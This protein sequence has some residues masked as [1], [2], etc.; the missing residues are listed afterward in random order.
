MAVKEYEV[1]RIEVTNP[2]SGYASEKPISARVSPPPI[3][4]RTNIND[5]MLLKTRGMD[6]KVLAGVVAEAAKGN[7][8]TG[9]AAGCVGRGC[10]DEPVVAEGYTKS[11]FSAGKSFREEGDSI[12]VFEKATEEV[13][14]RGLKAVGVDAP[15]GFSSNTNQTTI[16]ATGSGAD[17]APRLPTLG[18]GLSSTAKLL[19]LFPEGVGVVFDTKKKQYVLTLSQDALDTGLVIGGGQGSS[20]KPLDPDFGPRG[21][22]PVER[23][24]ELTPSTYLRFM[25]AGALCCSTVHLA[26]TPL[27]VVKT[28]L[29][30][31]PKDYPNPV[32]AFQKVLSNGLS[33]FFTGWDTTFAGFFVWGSIGYTLTEFLRRYITVAIDAPKDG[34]WEIPIVILSAS[35]GA[36]AGCF[37]LCPFETIRIRM[38]SG[39]GEGGLVSVAKNIISEKVKGAEERLE[40][41]DSQSNVLRVY[42]T[43]NLSARRFAHRRVRV[44]SSTP[45][46]RSS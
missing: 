8:S 19:T 9:G 35:L 33:T 7:D 46:R 3:T 37:F 21:R 27:D 38:V 29:Q 17:S 30:T 14:K 25:A 16:R 31:N 39:G 23:E 45:F 26:V 13:D 24:R 40:R 5:P 18:G 43:N 10:Y 22:S 20:P 41:S 11:E 15:Y 28:K 32:A 12:G 6:A 1:V 2:G 34:S 36:F 4:A 42:I 44:L